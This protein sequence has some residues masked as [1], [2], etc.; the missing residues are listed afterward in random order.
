MRNGKAHITFWDRTNL[1]RMHQGDITFH[2]WF[3]FQYL[4]SNLRKARLHHA[5]YQCGVHVPCAIEKLTWNTTARWVKLGRCRRPCQWPRTYVAFG[6]KLC[7]LSL[8]MSECQPLH[9]NATVINVADQKSECHR[10]GDTN[11]AKDL[12]LQSNSNIPKLALAD[13]GVGGRG[14]HL[15]LLIVA[16]GG[17]LAAET[18]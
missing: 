3:P 14:H 16:R 7:S 5:L 6:P 17:A 11:V 1:V 18:T 8:L 9:L 2:P 13:V 4:G 10:L 12:N 15:E